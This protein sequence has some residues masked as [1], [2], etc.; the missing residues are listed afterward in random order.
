MAAL[1]E[2]IL[3]SFVGLTLSLAFINGRDDSH[4][5]ETPTGDVLAAYAL[6][7]GQ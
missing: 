2:V 7:S 6:P 1:L 4:F 5:V 3:F